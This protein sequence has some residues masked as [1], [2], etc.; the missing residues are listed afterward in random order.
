MEFCD[1]LVVSE[2]VLSGV[3]RPGVGGAESVGFRSVRHGINQN[4]T[5][6][7]FLPRNRPFLPEKGALS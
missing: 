6:L 3:R 2:R 4:V 5:K 7:P 1:I